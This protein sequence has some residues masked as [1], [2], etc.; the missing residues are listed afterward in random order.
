VETWLCSWPA[1]GQLLIRISAQLYNDLGQF[2]HLA[3]LL[4]EALHGG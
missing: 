4:R 2:R 3:A 1:P